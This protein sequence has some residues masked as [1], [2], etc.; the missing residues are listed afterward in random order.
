MTRSTTKIPFN[1]LLKWENGNLGVFLLG[2][3]YLIFPWMTSGVLNETTAIFG[4][5]F[6]TIAV[7]RAKGSNTV[8]GGLCQAFIGVIYICAIGG[9]I[10]MATLWTTAIILTAIFFVLEMGF[11]KFG[12]ITKKADAF[13]IVPLTL[14]TFALL[15]AISGQSTL[16][17][18]DW[19]NMLVA[20]NYVSIFL[21]CALATLQLAGWNIAGKNTNKYIMLFAVLAIALAIFGTYQ[22]TLWQWT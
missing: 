5:M 16:F 21:F 15:M 20:L 18:I 22:G 2:L 8:V 6:L 1:A 10:S 12:P 9:L 4:L 11:F 3:F 17:V 7:M 19:G 14:M 13:Q